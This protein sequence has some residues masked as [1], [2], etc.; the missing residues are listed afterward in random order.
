[1]SYKNILWLGENYDGYERAYYQ[2]DLFTVFKERYT[3]FPYGPG[4][5]DYSSTNDIHDI[6][7]SLPVRPDLIVVSNT[8]KKF[9]QDADASSS[10]TGL[11]LEEVEIPKLM[12]LNKEYNRLEL[13]LDFIQDNEIDYV[14]SVLKDRC[15]EWESQTGATFIWEPFGVNLERFKPNSS[16]PDKYDF[17]FTGSLHEEWLDERKQVKE[18]LFK[19]RYQDFSWWHN[20]V[21]TRRFENRYDNLNIY[22]GEWDNRRLR[23]NNPPFKK[24]IRFLRVKRRAP[25]G[26]NYVSLLNKSK[27][28]LNTLSAVGIFNPRFWE[29]MATKTLILCPEDDY[30][31]LLEDGVNCVMYG[32]LS[33]FDNALQYYAEHDNDRKEIVETAYDEVQQYSWESIVDDI[34]ST[35]Q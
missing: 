15:T 20:L 1:M 24:D 9:E 2:N 34:M 3:V 6:I 28:F 10:S 16:V 11:Q 21:H 26:R 27:I 33:E 4:F 30:Y 18:H 5:S 13:K 7:N 31:G 29:L 25:F 12:F 35:I 19:S 23:L 8:W 22:W 17:A 32:D 14:T